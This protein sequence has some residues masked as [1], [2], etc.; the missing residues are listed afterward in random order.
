MK[1]LNVCLS[2]LDEE[3]G[4]VVGVAF[5]EN[6]KTWKLDNPTASTGQQV[7]KVKVKPPNHIQTF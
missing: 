3:L 5:Y 2:G 4:G 1:D 7:V 6:Y